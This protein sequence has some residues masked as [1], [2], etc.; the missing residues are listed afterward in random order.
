[1]NKYEMEQFEN[2]RNEIGS[3]KSLHLSLIGLLIIGELLV[4]FN[5]SLASGLHA[6]YQNKS[7]V[8]YLH[9]VSAISM[10][11]LF[12]AVILLGIYGFK[13]WLTETHIAMYSLIASV[14]VL[15]AIWWTVTV[16]GLSGG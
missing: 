14:L 12:S 16:L 4:I 8:D 1:M 13:K 9:L 2:D 10:V 3:N 5:Q 6:L 7:V 11:F 15:P